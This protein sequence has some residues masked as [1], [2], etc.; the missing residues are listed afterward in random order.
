M[1]IFFEC[2]EVLVIYIVLSMVIRYVFLK[3]PLPSKYQSIYHTGTIA[4]ALACVALFGVDVAVVAVVILS[5]VNLFL[6]NQDSKLYEILLIIPMIGIVDGLLLP[7]LILPVRMLSFSQK[8]ESAYVFCIYTCM[9]AGL[10]VFYFL[11]KSW[12][13]QFAYELGDRDLQK[14]EEILLGIIGLI[15]VVFSFVLNGSL[16]SLNGQESGEFKLILVLLGISSFV[17]TVSVIIVIYVGNKRAYFT[18]RV[19]DMQLNIITTMAEIVENR[20]KNTGGHIQRTATY[21]DIIVHELKDEGE[22]SD[23][24][25]EQYMQD[26]KIAAPLHDI[27]KIHISDS[28]LNKNG[29]LSDTEYTIM[30]THSKVGRDLLIQAK[31]NLGEFS[32]LDMAIDMAA[33]HH[34]WWD[35]S[36][37][38][39]PEGLKGDAI[40]LSAR[41][42]AVADVFDA[43]ISKR[44]Y[45]KAMP[46]DRAFGIIREETGSHFDPVVVNAF[47]RARTKIEDALV[48][49]EEAEEEADDMWESVKTRAF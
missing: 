20:D 32:Y 16:N 21:V 27:G 31:E 29:R 10:V 5:A 23:I 45:K 28:I 46:I 3:N 4:L 38:G 35:G 2:A 12:R 36:A 14:W 19:S 7:F 13:Q 42:M 44:V 26:I 30:K 43:L 1:N 37:K 40:P 9:F 22:F 6:A 47:F 17:M 11:G 39:Y 24:L 33:Y 34:E 48:D 8:A 49:F 15:L 18:S 25:T 41:I